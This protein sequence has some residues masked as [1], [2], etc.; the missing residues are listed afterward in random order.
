MKEEVPL[1]FVLVDG[2]TELLRRPKLKRSGSAKRRRRTYDTEIIMRHDV[3]RISLCR[4]GQ[5]ELQSIFSTE[6]QLQ[7]LDRRGIC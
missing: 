6:V 3:Q 2:G 7:L 5:V 4:S 1:E